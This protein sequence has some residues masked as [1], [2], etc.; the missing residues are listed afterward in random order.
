MILLT[1]VKNQ[2]LQPV[3][4]QGNLLVAYILLTIYYTS[5]DKEQKKSIL[6]YLRLVYQ[7]SSRP[8]K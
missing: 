1:Y 6:K 8:T 2:P 3:S 5:N 4:S 7:I